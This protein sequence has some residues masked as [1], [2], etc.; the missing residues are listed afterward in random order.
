MKV[1]IQEWKECEEEIEVQFPFYL[2]E[3]VDYKAKNLTQKGWTYWKVISPTEEICVKMTITT[4]DI[5]STVVE[6]EKFT[7]DKPNGRKGY[8]FPET[9]IPEKEWDKFTKKW[10]KIP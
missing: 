3:K 5:N 6:I 7:R 10:I 1:I 8:Y 4:G 2:R 9:P